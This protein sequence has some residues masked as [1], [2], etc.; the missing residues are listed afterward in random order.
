MI[1]LFLDEGDAK[2]AS[3][4]SASVKQSYKL[5]VP[6][7][8][9]C[10]KSAKELESNDPEHSDLSIAK[11][12]LLD[13]VWEKV[14]ISLARMLSPTPNGS[15]LLT[16]QHAVELVDLV[17]ISSQNVP[18]RHFSELCAIL[19]S[20][21]LK[22]L[23]V[24][25]HK[26]FEDE[27]LQ[28][29]R[30]E[31]LNLFAACFTGVCQ[32]QPKYKNLQVI[33]EQVLSATLEVISGKGDSNASEVDLSKNVNVRCCLLICNAMQETKGI[34]RL[35]IAVFPHLCQLVGAEEPRLRQAVGG[36]LF[37]VNVGKVLEEN[38]TRCEEA[39]ER[40]RKAESRVSQLSLELEKLRKE[41]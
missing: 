1:S 4:N 36:V 33:A 18:P 39:E 30:E 7:M 3:N 32:V 2:K 15:K 34:E 21:A 24:V 19:S 26:D 22:I 11:M 6:L 35:A 41:K 28:R 27:A 16:I 38:Q 25:R 8:A 10:L 40:A 5:L 29:C 20:G 12:R 17:N 13:N 31:D 37:R 9:V 23:E 14:C